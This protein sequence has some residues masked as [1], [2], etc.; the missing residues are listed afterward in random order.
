MSTRKILTFGF[1]MILGLVAVVATAQQAPPDPEQ[2]PL[3]Q[4]SH[5]KKKPNTVYRT[6]SLGVDSYH[7]DNPFQ[8]LSSPVPGHIGFSVMADAWH[9]SDVPRLPVGLDSYHYRIEVYDPK[10]TELETPLFVKE[11]APYAT[12]L[13]PGVVLEDHRTA[14]F[15]LG[16]FL[17]SDKTY[18]V[19]IY[20]M[21]GSEKVAPSHDRENRNYTKLIERKVYVR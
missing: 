6:F 1:G 11:S 5:G 18:T 19:R 2:P 8:L 10:D 16:P 15:V 12:P 4:S 17:P 13:Q 14:Q 7:P 21:K 20:M 3:P 9:G